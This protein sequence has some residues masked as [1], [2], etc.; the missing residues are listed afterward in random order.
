M[1]E[2]RVALV[3]G[4]LLHVLR[5][6]DADAL[7]LDVRGGVDA[8]GIV[9]HHEGCPQGLVLVPIDHGLVV[10]EPFPPLCL[11]LT[12]S[13]HGL[14]PRLPLMGNGRTLLGPCDTDGQ[15]RLDGFIAPPFSTEVA[16]PRPVLV[17]LEGIASAPLHID[18]CRESGTL[19]AVPH[20]VAV[21]KDTSQC[22][23]FQQVVALGKPGLIPAPVLGFLSIV[24]DVGHVP[25]VALTEDRRA[26]NLGMVARRSYDQAVFVRSL[27]LLVDFRHALL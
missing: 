25:L 8:A 21:G 6:R 14:L 4:P 22:P 24:N 2:D 10:R 16:H 18:Q 17:T 13:H 26:V 19:V 20:A 27:C 12:G 7:A 1:A 11:L 23:P 15:G 3:T 9:V 5:E